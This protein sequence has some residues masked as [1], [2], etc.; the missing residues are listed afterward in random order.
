MARLYTE[1]FE[2][3][4]ILFFTT[5]TGAAITTTP[6]SGVYCADLAATATKVLPSTYSEFYLRAG[7]NVNSIAAGVKI[8]M[9]WYKGT[10]II[11]EVHISGNKLEIQV[12]AAVVATGTRALAIGTWY[13]IEVHVKRANSGGEITAKID[14]ITECTFTGDTQPGADTVIDTISFYDSDHSYFDDLAMNDT[15]GAVDNSWCGD[16]RVIALTPNGDGDLSQLTN[17]LGNSTN[18]YS[19]VDEKPSNGDTDYVQGSVVDQKDLYA[20]TDC[21]LTG[22]SISRVWAE[23]R[24]RDTVAAGGLLALTIKTNSTEYSS[25]DIAL[26][27]T[28]SRVIGT[29]YP[30][31]PNTGVAWTIA[32]VDALQAGPKTRS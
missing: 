1:G 13:L 8:S 29:D 7:F 12:G 22:I 2:S 16:G 20:L 17:Q 15:S 5:P 9:G 14:G 10:T 28:Y 25:A 21:G 26:L 23:S 6:R 32:Q 24:S 3:G 18:N 4:D 27:N 19:Y 11:G 30:L 31:N